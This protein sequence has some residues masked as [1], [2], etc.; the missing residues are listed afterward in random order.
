MRRHLSTLTALILALALHY[1]WSQWNVYARQH[2]PVGNFFVVNS[3]N[4]SDT[5]YGYDPP[6]VY[7]RTI[8]RPFTGE[9]TA[10]IN[11]AETGVTACRGFGRSDYQ[12]KD[13]L[14]DATVTLS[15]FVSA[16]C[17]LFPGHYVVETVWRVQPEGYE[18]PKILRNVSNIFTVAARE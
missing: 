6:V 4:V 8:K 3:V 5:K 15:W 17:N 12:P 18:H 9:W 13:V 2:E 16:K 1:G 7:D 14:P 10:E 11:N